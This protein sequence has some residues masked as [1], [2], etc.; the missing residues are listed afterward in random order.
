MIRFLTR[1]A[2]Q[3]CAAGCCGPARSH[4]VCPLWSRLLQPESVSIG[5][6]NSHR[7]VHP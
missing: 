3:L 5:V 2:M 1:R 4:H 6:S 7:S